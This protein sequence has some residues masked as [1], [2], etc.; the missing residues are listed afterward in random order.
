MTKRR[1]ALALT[2]LATTAL[3]ALALGACSQPKPA[4]QTGTAQGEI[5]EASVSD[6][7]LPLDT[8]RS[9][10]PLAPKTAAGDV[11]AKAIKAGAVPKPARA[12]ASGSPEI[13]T[14]PTPT[15]EAS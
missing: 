11:A 12:T 1:S 4:K 5:L 8:V 10:T 9:Q 3:A 13:D 15:V 7:M 2:G 6:A 14:A